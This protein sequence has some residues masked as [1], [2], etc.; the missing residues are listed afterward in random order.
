VTPVEPAERMVRRVEDDHARPSRARAGEH[1]DRPSAR[2]RALSWCERLLGHEPQRVIGGEAAGPAIA[3]RTG[4]VRRGRAAHDDVERR[5]AVRSVDLGVDEVGVAA[6][7]QV[8]M[9]DPQAS[10]VSRP[11][12]PPRAANDELLAG[13]D[14]ATGPIEARRRRPQRDGAAR[15]IL[16]APDGPR[17]HEDR[18]RRSG[19]EREQAVTGQPTCSMSCDGLLHR[20]LPDGSTGRSRTW[21]T[22]TN[23]S[24]QRNGRDTPSRALGVAAASPSTLQMYEQVRASSAEPRCIARHRASDWPWNPRQERFAGSDVYAVVTK[25]GLASVSA[26]VQ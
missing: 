9:S 19:A 20:R 23:N 16:L 5:L 13:R 26:R 24:L 2:R 14:V 10:R 22:D 1:P 25:G 18:R 7:F 4:R 3:A 6:G 21:A 12:Q 15:P 11:R 17:E 8:A